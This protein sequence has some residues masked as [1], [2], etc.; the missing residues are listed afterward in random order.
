MGWDVVIAGTLRF[1]KGALEPWT[2]TAVVLT[3][4]GL[5][6]LIAM[7]ARTGGATSV[8]QLLD[9][10]RRFGESLPKGAPALL[11]VATEG[12]TMS[13][14]AMLPEDDY[15]DVGGAL[16]AIG[17]AASNAGASGRV[18]FC[19]VGT[20]RGDVLIVDEGKTIFRRSARRMDA[21]DSRAF[22]DVWARVDEKR[23]APKISPERWARTMAAIKRR[24]E[25]K[26]QILAARALLAKKK[27]AARRKAKAKGAASKKKAP[28][29]KR[30]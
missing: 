24:H 11:D 3:D 21:E 20:R 19:N 14:R 18:L 9:E 27:A 30:K 6:P 10:C 12:D 26:V 7:A 22:S 17:S 5:P 2:R 25:K 4:E 16:V 29:K 13:I 23:G 28:T 8:A 1:A 15:R